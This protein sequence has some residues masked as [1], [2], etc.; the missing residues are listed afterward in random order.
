MAEIRRYASGAVD[1]AVGKAKRFIGEVA[2]RPDIVV[3]GDAQEK[4]GRAE[5]AR[6]RAHLSRTPR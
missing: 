2:S 6:A 1:E 4:R 3:E 5:L